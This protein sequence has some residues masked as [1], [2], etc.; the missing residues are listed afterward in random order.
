[1]NIHISEANT[2]N[3][4]FEIRIEKNERHTDF[5]YKMY[6]FSGFLIDIHSIDIG[7]NGRIEI[8]CIP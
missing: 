3:T 2:V 1:M 5:E 8:T 7:K 4:L 6:Q